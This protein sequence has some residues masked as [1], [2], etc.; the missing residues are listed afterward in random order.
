MMICG[1]DLTKIMEIFQCEW[2]A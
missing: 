1:G 2:N